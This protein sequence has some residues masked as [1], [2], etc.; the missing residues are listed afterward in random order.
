MLFRPSL[1]K[2]CVSFKCP[3]RQAAK[4][5]AHTLRESAKPRS[6]Q[7]CTSGHQWCM[8]A[9]EGPE[10]ECPDALLTFQLTT[11]DPQPARPSAVLV[12]P[13]KAAVAAALTETTLITMVF[14]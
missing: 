14:V 11:G 12:Q 9:K 7:T 13:L 2:T 5:F 1:T 3:R 8:K 4:A 10:S 6:A